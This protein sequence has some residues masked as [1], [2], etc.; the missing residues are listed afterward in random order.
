[1]TE[2]HEEF[3]SVITRL[4]LSDTYVLSCFLGGLKKDV[5]MIVRMFQPLTVSRVFALAR[6]YEVV[7]P[8]FNSNKNQRGVLG[9][10]STPQM[11]SQPN[12]HTK[13]KFQRNLT[14]PYMS[15]RRAKGLCYF[16]DEPYSMDDITVEDIIDE[17]REP[18]Q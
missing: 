15:E 18:T 9:P 17:E 5:Q 11:G 16:C 7:N 10:A 1:V 12:S 3:D 4:N 6:M 2:Y 8:N 13:P 14:P